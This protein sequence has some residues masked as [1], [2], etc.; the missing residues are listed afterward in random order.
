MHKPTLLLAC[1]VLIG[2]STAAPT[3]GGSDVDAGIVD[4]GIIV[5]AGLI[6]GGRITIVTSD[7]GKLTLE[8]SEATGVDPSTLTARRRSAP[9]LV[10]R[11][12]VVLAYELSPDGTRFAAPV[13][14]RFRGS[15]GD[16][17]YFL[18]DAGDELVGPYVMPGVR[19]TDGGREPLGSPALAFELSDG[20][21]SFSG[22]LT[23]FTDVEL[24]KPD[25][26]RF[27]GN[28]A[29][30]FMGLGQP[31]LA[32]SMPIVGLRFWLTKQVGIPGGLELFDLRGTQEV[33]APQEFAFHGGL[34]LALAAGKHF[35]F[36]N[37]PEISM[38]G[39]LITGPANSS[40]STTLKANLKL[41]TE[42]HFGFIGVPE[43]SLSATVALGLRFQGCTET[44]TGPGSAEAGRSVGLG[45]LHGIPYARTCERGRFGLFTAP[46]PSST[47]LRDEASTNPSTF[48]LATTVEDSPWRIFT[49]GL[50]PLYHFSILSC[51]ANDWGHTVCPTPAALPLEGDFVVL[52]TVMGG[53]VPLADPAN[54]YIYSFVFDADNVSANNYRAPARYPKDFYDDTDR[55]YEASWVPGGAWV[56]TA[57]TARGGT[58]TQ[59]PTAARLVLSG[60]TIFFIAPRSEFD[61]AKP[62]WRFTAFRHKGDY[63]LNPPYDWN[64]DV[65]PP[66]GMPL[67]EFP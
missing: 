51:G 49:T 31:A 65:E 55:W 43:L 48:T 37:V 28:I 52:S 46:T 44:R 5:D 54:R 58:V 19:Q 12:D 8:V 67:F 13:T 17:G 1:A 25:H 20:G 41:G 6:D 66:V 63:G 26:E 64:G 29:V 47:G 35:A 27:V 57:K 3:D 45:Q 36:N 21:A 53:D 50:S 56:L 24:V 7:D 40:G 18:S 60:D 38:H 32:P 59:V 23:H 61:V 4:A 11:D 16:M 2:C 10:G 30:G 33:T 15:A 42:I 39:G 14:V 34:P 9:E 62:R 22:T